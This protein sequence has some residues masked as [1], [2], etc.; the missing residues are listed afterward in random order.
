MRPSLDQWL[1]EAKAAPGAENCGMYLTHCGTVRRT[2]KA[3][4][5]LGQADSRDVAGMRFSYDAEKVNAAIE[6][7]KALE[8]I[9]HVR[10][11]LNEGALNL[12]DDI[13]LVLIGGDIRP[14]VVDALQFLVGRIKNECVTEEEIYE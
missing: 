3:K 12:G 8:G 9:F 2:A 7:T 6:E 14:H 4:V 5:R 13:M 11:W 1:A 10:V